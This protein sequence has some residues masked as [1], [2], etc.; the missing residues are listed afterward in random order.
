MLADVYSLGAILYD[1]VTGR[2]PFK[3]ATVFDTLAQVVNDEPV[4]PRQLN[5]RVPVDLDTI[6]LKC[7]HKDPAYRYASAAALADDLARFLTGEPIRARPV[8]RLKRAVMWAWRHPAVVSLLAV[9]VLA[10]LCVMGIIA[11][12]FM[13]SRKGD[14]IAVFQRVAE[15]Q[16]KER[17]RRELDTLLSK[18]RLDLAGMVNAHSVRRLEWAKSYKLDWIKVAPPS[19]AGKPDLFLADSE[20]KVAHDFDTLLVRRPHYQR[21]EYYLDRKRPGNGPVFSRSREGFPDRL[22]RPLAPSDVMVK[23]AAR[24]DMDVS[25]SQVQT[26]EATGCPTPFVV[27]EAC[28]PVVASAD[29]RRPSGLLVVTADFKPW[30]QHLNRFPGYLDEQQGKRE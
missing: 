20:K 7:L 28:F 12:T 3:A 6:C 9:S 2:P 29:S 27:L 17:S 15:E 18:M 21:L 4:P 14:A 23:R 13:A 8:G 30:T 22:G 16:A 25:F 10:S 5:P 26:W 19:Y 1:C 11:L 24:A